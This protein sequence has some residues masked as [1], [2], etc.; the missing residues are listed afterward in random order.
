MAEDLKK[1]TEEK[2]SN[3]PKPYYLITLIFIILFILFYQEYAKELARLVAEQR[4][5]ATEFE[6]KA[7]ECFA[8]KAIRD[9]K[10]AEQ[11]R[12]A[13]EAAEKERLKEL[14][15]KVISDFYQAVKEHD[16]ITAVQLRANYTEA[17][18]KKIRS[19]R[20]N[21]AK[22]VKQTPTVA[23]AYIKI[24]YRQ[25]GSRTKYHFAGYLQLAKQDET[26]VII[27]NFSSKYS[28][29]DYLK[30]YQIPNT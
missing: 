10:E 28:L 2:N 24:V 27:G 17:E 4:V 22:I 7:K 19:I 20:L 16:C 11:K 13:A 26:W 12:L 8:E 1:S 21:D 9:A 30:K 29:E 23:V 5:K 14:Q 18:C 6:A 25:K 3:N 15:L